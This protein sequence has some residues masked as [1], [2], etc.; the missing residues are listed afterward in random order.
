MPIWVRSIACQ[1]AVELVTSYL[2]GTLSRSEKRRFEAHIADCPHCHE[3][4]DQ[5][6]RTIALTGTL[7]EEDLSP[8]AREDL[9]ALYRQW[10]AE[11][12]EGG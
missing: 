2:E 8:E 3:Y 11:P 4:L 1:E 6:R 12:D 10:K 9:S 5:M 7:K